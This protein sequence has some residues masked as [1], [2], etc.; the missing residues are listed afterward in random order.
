MDNPGSCTCR[1]QALE[2]QV[3][4]ILN[5]IGPVKLDAVYRLQAL[6]GPYATVAKMQDTMQ[7]VK[8]RKGEMRNIMTTENTASSS[9][10]APLH[11]LA[12]SVKDPFWPPTK[13]GVSAATSNGGT[14]DRWKTRA[15]FPTG[16]QAWKD[17]NP[18]LP[19]GDAGYKH[20]AGPNVAATGFLSEVLL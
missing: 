7:E 8:G 1:C 17:Y 12:A 5:V 9:H 19:P 20:T 13:A 10:V 16:G 15:R 3:A 6:Q 11:P 4:S 2:A 18:T 14:M